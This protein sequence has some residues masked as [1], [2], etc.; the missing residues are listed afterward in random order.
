VRK[1]TGT[2]GTTAKT[3]TT[4]AKTKTTKA[5]AKAKAKPRTKTRAT[6]KHKAKAKTGAKPARK[7]VAT[8]GPAT[9]DLPDSYGT[10]R[11][12]LTARDPHWLYSYWDLT[13]SQMDAYRRRAGDNQLVL[14]VCQEGRARPIQEIT[15]QEDSRNWYIY[16]NQAATTYTAQLG[17]KP[18]RGAFKVVCRSGEATTPPEVIAPDQSAEFVT[19]PLDIPF[20]EIRGMVREHLHESEPLGAGLQR[21]EAGGAKWFGQQPPSEPW[22]EEQADVLTHLVWDNL[23]HRAQS[24]S[25]ELSE[26]LRR[27]LSEELSSGLFSRLGFSPTSG[28][29]PVPKPADL[30]SSSKT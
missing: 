23:M 8:T 7:A 29:W 15:L 21:L 1:R 10:G 13:Q 4:K 20:E 16:V 5:G 12:Y 11:M 3:K 9:A 14:R 26:W 30:K 19:I 2:T 17:Y 18:R 24:G 22:T 27:Q 28:S 6:S 25:V